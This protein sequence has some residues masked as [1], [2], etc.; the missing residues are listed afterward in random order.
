V[1]EADCLRS[2]ERAA[3]HLHGRS[4]TKLGVD[5]SGH[6]QVR[7]ARDEPE[8]LVARMQSKS[9]KAEATSWCTRFPEYWQGGAV[10]RASCWQVSKIFWG[11]WCRT[12]RMK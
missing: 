1:A 2:T 9:R 12:H 7:G 10:L 3:E 6:C 5:I 11:G 4:Q 8:E